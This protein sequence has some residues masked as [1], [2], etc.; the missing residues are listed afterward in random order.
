MKNKVF[1]ACGIIEVMEGGTGATWGYDRY[2]CTVKAVS[3]KAALRRA[4]KMFSKL[5]ENKNRKEER[6]TNQNFRNPWPEDY[7]ERDFI[8]AS[9]KELGANNPPDLFITSVGSKKAIWF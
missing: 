4:E 2:I 8:R 5:V 9:V 3:K 6:W 1:V 7:T